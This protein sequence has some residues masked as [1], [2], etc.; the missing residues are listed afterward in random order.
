MSRRGSARF[1]PNSQIDCWV[2]LIMKSS[3][4]YSLKRNLLWHVGK[5]KWEK[6]CLLGVIRAPRCFCSHSPAN[7]RTPGD[8]AGALPPGGLPRGE[9]SPTPSPTTCRGRWSLTP[10]S[11]N[12]LIG[13]REGL[14]SLWPQEDVNLWQDPPNQECSRLPQLWAQH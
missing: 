5:G 14:R 3:I 6:S 4:F 2:P 11:A 7:A 12:S 9:G 1:S 8:C 13:G 10:Q